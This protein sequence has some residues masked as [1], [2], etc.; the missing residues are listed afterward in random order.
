MKKS[1]LLL[2]AT[3]LFSL[4]TLTGCPNNN[5][6]SVEPSS[7]EVDPEANWP[8]HAWS[9]DEKAFI[10]ARFG[11]E[12]DLPSLI[13]FYYI[14]GQ[15]LKNYNTCLSIEAPANTGSVADAQAYERKLISAGFDQCS[16]STSEE[17]H[18]RKQ[19]KSGFARVTFLDIKAYMYNGG[20]TIDVIL[21]EEV[22][23]HSFAGRD[24]D[25]D[26]YE[27]VLEG[28]VD[29][30]K[31]YFAGY[32]LSGTYAFSFPTE[33]S[34]SSHVIQIDFLDYYAEMARAY[35]SQYGYPYNYINI[36]EKALGAD[37]SSPIGRFAFTSSVQTPQE[38]EEEVDLVD[39]A[40]AGESFAEVT[41]Y[42]ADSKN[43]ANVA[44]TVR[45]NATGYEVSLSGSE[46]VDGTGQDIGHPAYV[47]ADVSF[48]VFHDYSGTFYGKNADGKPAAYLQAGQLMMD[49]I[50]PILNSSGHTTSVGFFS[51]YDD[52]VFSATLTDLRYYYASTQGI[53][54]GPAFQIA[55][56]GWLASD[57][58]IQN[59]F[60]TD[61][62]WTF[63]PA[64]EEDPDSYDHFEYDD[65]EAT[66]KLSGTTTKKVTI[67]IYL[68]DE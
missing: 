47:Y 27:T 62:G 41:N 46:Y 65:W 6:P 63:V 34:S 57:E 66:A 9:D 7:S 48:E 38:L 24:V 19:L 55:A 8:V 49:Y 35:Y 33:L 56:T 68:A 17:V 36:L 4:G 1:I 21:G 50:R 28:V 18:Y 39:S 61:C 37:F 31:S 45:R 26:D 15:T 59:F 67:Q 53:D 11:S 20:F 10:T 12:F 29:A 51:N 13:P 44:S 16:D 64:T 23:D 22:N 5:A 2:T 60:V 58:E 52:R 42:K 54:I 30:A 25:L 14:E 32:G 43:N 3:A 40:L